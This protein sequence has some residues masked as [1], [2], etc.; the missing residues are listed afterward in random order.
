MK[1][2]SKEKSSPTLSD[3][4]I[5]T[6]KKTCY[7]LILI[8]GLTTRPDLVV[9][10]SSVGVLLSGDPHCCD[11]KDDGVISTVCG[12]EA[13]CRRFVRIGFPSCVTTT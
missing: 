10:T 12:R 9:L 4:S 1:T 13:R 3:A 6:K 2:S 7:R 8:G 5:K 11:G